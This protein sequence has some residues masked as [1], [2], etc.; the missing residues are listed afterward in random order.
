[1]K[2]KFIV[3]EGIDGSGK[4]TQAK[5]LADKL[6]AQG[7]NTILTFEPTFSFYGSKL[8]DSFTT[9]RLSLEEE[10]ELFVLDRREHIKHLIKP[11]IEEGYT[12]VLD[13]YYYSTVAYQ[14]ARGADI[15][16]IK[17]MHKDFLIEPDAAFILQLPVGI[18]I[19]RIEENRKDGTNTFEKENYL[20]KVSDIFNNYFS[21]SNIYYI[22]SNKDVNSLERSIWE[23]V[24]TII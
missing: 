12:I 9:K 17:D 13:R 2:G 16:K 8:R 19:S 11:A 7:I 21:G 4:S 24:S 18:A 20:K 6:V 1:M 15:E 10:L 22:N 23:I 14:G 3:F 5:I